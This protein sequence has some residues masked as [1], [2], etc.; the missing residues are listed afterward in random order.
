[1]AADAGKVV[2]GFTVLD[3]HQ[4]KRYMKLAKDLGADIKDETVSPA[5]TR[6]H[7][8]YSLPA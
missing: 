8:A 6:S 5:C 7:D 2:I 4:K 3:K 1:M